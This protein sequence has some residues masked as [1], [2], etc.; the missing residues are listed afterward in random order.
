MLRAAETISRTVITYSFPDVLSYSYKHSRQ[1]YLHGIFTTANF[2]VPAFGD[3]G[4]ERYS[5]FRAPGFE[6]WDMALLKNTPIRESM[7]FQLRFEFFN[8]FNHPN[9]NSVV[10]D[11]SQSNF[12]QAT[13][14][15]VPRFLQVGGNFTF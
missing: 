7:A 15:N 14:Q 12:G 6:Q 9:L 8:I 11:Q 2:A 3:E 5:A 10:T 1:D 4:N 13:G